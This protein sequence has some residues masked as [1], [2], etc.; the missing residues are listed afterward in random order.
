MNE[1][2][3]QQAFR[4]QIKLI[5]LS[6]MFMINSVIYRTTTYETLLTSKYS[7]EKEN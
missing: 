1:E 5:K 6:L 3:N 2:E 4:F 7:K